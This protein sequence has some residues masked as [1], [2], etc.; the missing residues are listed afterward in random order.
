MA[1]SGLGITSLSLRDAAVPWRVHGGVIQLN[2]ATIRGNILSLQI[3]GGYD[4]LNDRLSA[5][6]DPAFF[7]GFFSQIFAPLSR[8]VS[9]RLSGSL[10][11]P[12]WSLR[13]TPLRWFTD[14]FAP[15]DAE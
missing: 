9:F 1:E 7:S 15:A 13:L 6:V 4:Y 2:D 12:Q 8:N 3:N 14:Q 10:D 11:E 5:A